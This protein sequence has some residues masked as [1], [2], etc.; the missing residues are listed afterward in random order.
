MKKPGAEFHKK[1]LV[2]EIGACY[3]AWI[4]FAVATVPDLFRLGW[5]I[6]ALLPLI[7]P[8]GLLS[9][10]FVLT[11]NTLSG[12]AII[13]GLAVSCALAAPLLAWRWQEAPTLIRRALITFPPAY[14]G[15]LGVFFTLYSA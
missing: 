6:I 5:E 4:G 8:V 9:L 1:R 13:Y 2:G 12:D 3:F 10:I 14:L 15:T 7:A 11:P